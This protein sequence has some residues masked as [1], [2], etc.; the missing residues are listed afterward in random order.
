QD[1]T[2]VRDLFAS[3]PWDQLVPD[4]KHEVVVDGLGEF[5]GLDYLAAARTTD[6]ATVIAYM[7]TSR[8]ITVDMTKVSGKEAKAWWF[9]PRTGKSDSIGTVPT[10]GKHRF[11]PPGEGDWVLLLDDASRGLRA[12]GKS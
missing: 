10:L 8:A 1:M 4:D 12:P 2:R 11:D 3:R 7:P 5:R 6:G 9:N